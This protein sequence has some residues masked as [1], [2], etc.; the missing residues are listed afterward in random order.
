MHESFFGINIDKFGLPYALSNFYL[1]TECVIK[2]SSKSSLSARILEEK[3]Y[4]AN[5]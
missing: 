4:L 2:R 5:K 1:A 3:S